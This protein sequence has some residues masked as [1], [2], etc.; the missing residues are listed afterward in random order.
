M[1]CCVRLPRNLKRLYELPEEERLALAEAWFGLLVADVALRLIP[2]G[3]FRTRITSPLDP[4]TTTEDK[5]ECLRAQRYSELVAIAARHHL[6]PMR[7]LRQ[8]IAL[9]W[10]LKRRGIASVLRIGI[11]RA[12]AELHAHAWLEYA[13]QALG[14]PAGISRIFAPLLPAMP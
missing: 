5:R 2:I 6:Y 9:Q 11:Q 3:R 13:G 8:A 14:Q 10:M 1:V 7:C 4:R 12:G